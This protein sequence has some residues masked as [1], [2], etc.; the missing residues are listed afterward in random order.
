MSNAPEFEDFFHILRHYNPW[1]QLSRCIA[2]QISLLCE[3]APLHR[4]H[5]LIYRNPRHFQEAEMETAPTHKRVRSH[6]DQKCLA[7]IRQLS[8]DTRRYSGRTC[9]SQLRPRRPAWRHYSLMHGLCLEWK[10][11][12]STWNREIEIDSCYLQCQT[13]MFLYSRST[14]ILSPMEPFAPVKLSVRL[15]NTP[16]AASA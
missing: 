2:Q 13:T 3:D 8:D 11:S 10:I 5:R 14:C 7:R 6:M 16:A 12:H 9:H 4:L 15:N 1:N